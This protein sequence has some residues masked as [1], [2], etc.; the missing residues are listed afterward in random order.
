[1]S[2]EKH[3]CLLPKYRGEPRGQPKLLKGGV[4]QVTKQGDIQSS[5]KST[6][7]KSINLKTW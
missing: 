1:M 2:A 4:P 3:K 5:K 6:P 7:H